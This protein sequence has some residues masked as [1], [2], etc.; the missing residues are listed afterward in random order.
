M[1]NTPSKRPIGCGTWGQDVL[2]HKNKVPLIGGDNLR[3]A[4]VASQ[5]LVTMTSF[6]VQRAE[7]VKKAPKNAVPKER[8]PKQ[9]KHFQTSSHSLF[10]LK[11]NSV[12]LG[13]SATNVNVTPAETA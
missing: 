9:E 11:H 13:P 5:Y 1:D 6:C 2:S 7:G 12:T 3:N 10:N 4:A 8:P